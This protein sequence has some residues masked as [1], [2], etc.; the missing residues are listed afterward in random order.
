MSIISYF[1]LS[2]L[3]PLPAARDTAPV[4][5]A[6]AK[7]L[8]PEAL[9][10][11]AV[12]HRN[13]NPTRKELLHRRVLLQARFDSGGA[14]PDFLPETQHIRDDPTWTG[15]PPMPG[16][17]DRRVEITGPVDRKMVS[18]LSNSLRQIPLS[19]RWTHL[20]VINALN[21][22]AATFMA[23][24]EG[25]FLKTLHLEA[26]VFTRERARRAL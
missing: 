1:H 11:L 16:L 26:S 19:T 20:Q 25:Q 23:D 7:I 18:T 17:E 3:L 21:S 13:F 12:L 2:L 8:T 22:G 10:F 14:L 15:P 9:K 24:F 5:D 6:H 4:S